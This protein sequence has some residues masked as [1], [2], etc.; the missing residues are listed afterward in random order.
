MAQNKIPT[1]SGILNFFNDTVASA[2]FD[3]SSSEALSRTN[4]KSESMLKC[5]SNIQRAIENDFSEYPT[6]LK[7]FCS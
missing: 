2:E 3:E 1:G 5:S 7:R 4:Q 6:L